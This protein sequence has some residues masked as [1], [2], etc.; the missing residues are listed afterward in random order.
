MKLIHGDCLLV[1][2]IYL[3]SVVLVKA[4]IQYGGNF[5]QQQKKYVCSP[6]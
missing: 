6:W 5:E 3:F 2:F 1:S 4:N